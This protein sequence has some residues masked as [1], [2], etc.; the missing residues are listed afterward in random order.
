[1]LEMFTQFLKHCREKRGP[2]IY[3]TIVCTKHFVSVDYKL[4]PIRRVFVVIEN[5]GGDLTYIGADV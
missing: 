1:M 5:N 2:D 3:R 4:S